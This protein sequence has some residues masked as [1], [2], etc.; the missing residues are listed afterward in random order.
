MFYGYCGLCMGGNIPQI[1]G[2]SVYSGGNVPQI[3][4]FSDIEEE[5][6]HRYQDFC[7]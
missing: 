3:L 7:I 4:G 1:L 5:M 6:L 2:V